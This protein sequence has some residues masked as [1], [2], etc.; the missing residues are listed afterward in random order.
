[1][2]K[3]GTDY[4]RVD[5]DA[6][7]TPLWVADVIFQAIR[8]EGII[9]DPA[10]GRGNILHVAQ[11]HHGGRARGLD[12]HTYEDPLV[13]PEIIVE[14]D[15][16]AMQYLPSR[17]GLTHVVKNPPFGE[18]GE[19]AVRFIEHA[20]DLTEPAGGT[21][22]ALLPSDFDHASTRRHIFDRH[23]AYAGQYKLLNRVRWTNLEQK[24]AGPKT[25]CTWFHWDWS[26]SPAAEPWVGY[27][28][29][30]PA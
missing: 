10:A 22:T 6:Y 4:P 3:H 18:R 26:K 9:F 2:G 16:L 25:N 30:M 12:I 19:T 5:R 1:M 21:V 24:P 20:L 8:F 7:F 13:E 28:G 27:L 29:R 23:P 17:W 14:G 11:K 15:F